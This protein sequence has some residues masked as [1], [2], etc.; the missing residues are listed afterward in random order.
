[1]QLLALRR[2]VSDVIDDKATKITANLRASTESELGFCISMQLIQY[3]PLP[4]DFGCS[5]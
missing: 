2:N 1:M 5:R 4:N 3:L